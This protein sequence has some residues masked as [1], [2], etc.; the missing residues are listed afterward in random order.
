[1][2]L[3][4]TAAYCYS[5][6]FA[7]KVAI[8]MLAIACLFF[9]NASFA[10]SL[11]LPQGNKHL[12]FLE[13]LEIMLQKNPDLNLA[14]AK[15]VSRHVAVDI[16]GLEDSSSGN[17]QIKLS[18]VDQANLQSLL[19]NNAEWVTRDVNR[20]GIFK[21]FYKN[22]ANFAEINKEKFF[23]AL[24]PM[25]YAEPGYEKDNDVPVYNYAGGANMRGMIGRGFGFYASA[26]RYAESPPSYVRDWISQYN[27]VPGAGD[28]DTYHKNTY[29][30]WDVRGGLTFKALKYFDFEV[31]Y[32][33][34]FLG[35][36]YR[37][38]FLSDFGKSYV[39]GKATTRI[40][41][42]QYT[43]IYAPLIPQFDG[44]REANWPVGKRMT[45]FHHLSFNATKW[46][47]V[48]LFQSVAIARSGDWA[49]MVPVIYYPVF[50]FKDSKP[51]NNLAGFEFKANVAK[52]HQ[53]YG[54]FLIDNFKLK[55]ITSGNG[56]WNNRFGVQLGAKTINL[57]G[58]D[59]LDLQVE[60]NAVRP[61]TYASDSIGSYTHYNQP[62]AHPLG[63]NFFE[64]LAILRFQ[65]HKRINFRIQI[66]VWKQGMDSANHNFGANIRINPIY[67]PNEFGFTIPSG[68]EKN[69][70][71]G[72]LLFN[73]EL[74]E[75]LF[76][77]VY[78][79]FRKSSVEDKA[80]ANSNRIV[81]G[82]ALRF[83]MYRHNFDY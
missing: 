80:T 83:N 25:V 47:N 29:L 56:W 79:S 67:R 4:R 48:A 14:S 30:Y 61:Y 54:Q 52:K 60:M 37:S 42:F 10:Q 45:V 58:V 78:T 6:L 1:M 68:I 63:A 39:F 33:Q 38:L 19:R 77:D 73:Y 36:G 50:A 16:A 7:T 72:S 64:G 46:L 5:R 43:H 41:K 49:Y 51:A 24:N 11:Y 44:K 62:L 13:R 8:T 53:F 21:T 9:S 66:N 12:P 20:K 74:L 2:L 26:V 34:N 71:N 57:F 76:L 59:N 18:K 23:F 82:V 70:A 40:W 28:Y 17:P 75:N 31:A 3:N 27:A 35:N 69:V 32:D 65:P 81:Y 15:S 22:Q 55:E